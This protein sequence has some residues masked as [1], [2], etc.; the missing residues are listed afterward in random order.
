LHEQGKYDES[1]SLFR[2]SLEIMRKV[3]GE[4]HP[5]VAALLNNLAALLRAQ[6]KYYEACVYGRQALSIV[7]RAL[8]SNHPIAQQLRNNWA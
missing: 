7:N 2:Q 8:G 6:G 1:I 3:L 4:E 5:N